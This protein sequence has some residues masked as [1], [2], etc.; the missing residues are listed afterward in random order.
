MLLMKMLLL[1]REQVGDHR[2]SPDHRARWIR[3][4]CGCSSRRKVQRPRCA[5]VGRPKLLLH[6]VL[7]LLLVMQVVGPWHPRS[8]SSLRPHTRQRSRLLHHRR[9]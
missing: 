2:G 5:H 8:P 3:S 9:I 1:R 4:C 7:H 6:R